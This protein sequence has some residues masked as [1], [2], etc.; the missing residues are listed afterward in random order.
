MEDFNLNTASAPDEDDDLYHKTTNNHV[1]ETTP[2]TTDDDY[3]VGFDGSKSS[4]KRIIFTKDYLYHGF[5]PYIVAPNG[6]PVT[7]SVNMSE[8][9]EKSL[10]ASFSTTDED[11]WQYY[12]DFSPGSLSASCPNRKRFVS[13]NLSQNNELV[14]YGAYHKNIHFFRGMLDFVL[15]RKLTR[16]AVFRPDHF[17]PKDV[18]AKCD[19]CDSN[20]VNML[21]VCAR[22]G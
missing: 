8:E 21:S 7:I 22:I 18:Y 15:R 14:S 10:T 1:K 11:G 12:T 17:L 2:N 13:Q 20:V 16:I 5:A 9:D 4:I 3:Y 19:F 6:D